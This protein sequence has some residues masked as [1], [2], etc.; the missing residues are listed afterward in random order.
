M[1]SWRMNR[2]KWVWLIAGGAVLPCAIWF[3]SQQA[4]VVNEVLEWMHP[5]AKALAEVAPIGTL[6]AVGTASFLAYRTFRYRARVDDA[7]QWWKRAQY[8]IDL[9]HGT[10]EQKASGSK[11]IETLLGPWLKNAVGGID[12]KK[13]RKSAEAYGWRVSKEEK[14]MLYQILQNMLVG[15]PPTQLTGDE[16]QELGSSVPDTAE[17]ETSTDTQTWSAEET[18]MNSRPE[19]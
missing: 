14:E 10:D 9:L 4:R 5:G 7:D 3:F 16:L 12:E 11:V 13:I 8:G 6:L 19:R 17:D 1:Y 15:S 18:K 2:A